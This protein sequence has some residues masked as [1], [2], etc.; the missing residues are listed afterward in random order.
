[1][2][3]DKPFLPEHNPVTKRVDLVESRMR[4]KTT[5][6]TISLFIVVIAIFVLAPVL[7][8]PIPRPDQFA[9][10]GNI[11]DYESLSCA[12]FGVGYSY[13][14]INSVGGWTYELNCPG[15]HA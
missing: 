8:S 5:A 4:C 7:Y 11:P 2:H 6:L 1:M 14:S 13:Y 12:I 3:G 15:H 10:L 9:F